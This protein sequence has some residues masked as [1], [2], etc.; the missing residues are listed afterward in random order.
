MDEL[1]ISRRRFGTWLA[2][3]ASLAAA[4]PA[5]GLAQASWPQPGR[6]IR[7]LVGLAAG[8]S[9]DSQARAVARRLGEIAGTQVVVENRPGASMMLSASEAMGPPPHRDTPTNTAPAHPHTPTHHTTN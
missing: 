4:A 3:A 8:G 1:I 7:I 5:A 9:L 2:G 6:P